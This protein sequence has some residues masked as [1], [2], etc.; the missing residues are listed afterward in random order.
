MEEKPGEDWWGGTDDKYD[1]CVKSE[2]QG[3]DE[4]QDQAG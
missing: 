2:F 1:I 3:Y 4:N